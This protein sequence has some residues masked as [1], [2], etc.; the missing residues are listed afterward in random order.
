[1]IVPTWPPEGSSHKL[2]YYFGFRVVD[3]LGSWV[4]QGPYDTNDQAK[5]ARESAKAWDAQ[6]TTPF[7]ASSKDE[8]LTKCDIF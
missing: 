7:V 8:A 6:V 4:V 3:P 2:K 5:V 1:M